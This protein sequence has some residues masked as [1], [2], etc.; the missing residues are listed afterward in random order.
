VIGTS[1]MYATDA[2]CDNGMAWVGNHANDA[3]FV[4]E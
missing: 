4:E 1:Q 2:A 3:E